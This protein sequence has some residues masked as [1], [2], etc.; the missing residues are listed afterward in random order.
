[1]KSISVTR[2]NFFH[3]WRCAGLIIVCYLYLST[4][5]VPQFLHFRQ[6]FIVEYTPFFPNGNQPTNWPDSIRFQLGMCQMFDSFSDRRCK[7]SWKLGTLFLRVL[8]DV[9]G[10]VEVSE[11]LGWLRLNHLFVPNFDDG[12]TVFAVVDQPEGELL[13]TLLW[14]VQFRHFFLQGWIRVTHFGVSQL[15]SCLISTLL[16]YKWITIDFCGLWS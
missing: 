1:M 11:L 5:F 6:I 16:V 12:F 8:N 9:V 4:F 13:N 7:L 2:F 3:R 10:E 14:I 15:T